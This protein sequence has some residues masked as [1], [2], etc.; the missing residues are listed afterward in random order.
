MKGQ[1]EV[2]GGSSRLRP[3]PPQPWSSIST[4]QRPWA[5]TE[6]R[7][8]VPASVWGLLIL[9][10]DLG[11]G[12][13]LGYVTSLKPRWLPVCS[14]LLPPS[15][16]PPYVLLHPFVSFRYPP[17]PQPG[18]GYLTSSLRALDGG[19]PAS[20]LASAS[21]GN[22]PSQ[23]ERVGITSEAHRWQSLLILGL[24]VARAVGQ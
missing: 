9:T 13:E 14:P 8:S 3:P 1:K 6:M 21:C 5:V 2:E 22:L 15:L 23:P 11:L 19:A 7:A 16:T 20:A 12:N 24:G 10:G 17:N 4:N 18:L